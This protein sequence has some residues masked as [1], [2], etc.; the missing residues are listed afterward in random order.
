MQDNNIKFEKKKNN[1]KIKLMLLFV[2]A[3]SWFHLTKYLKVKPL[4][5]EITGP[6]EENLEK[7]NG[8]F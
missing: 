8:H 3:A 6:W 7:E 2:H 5:F 1:K 4:I